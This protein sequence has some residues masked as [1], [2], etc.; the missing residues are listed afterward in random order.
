MLAMT[1]VGSITENEM[2]ATFLQAEAF[3]PRFKQ[4]VLISAERHG[5]TMAQLTNIDISD[6]QINEKRAKVLGELRGFRHNKYLFAGLPQNIMWQKGLIDRTDI[7]RCYYAEHDTWNAISLGTRMVDIG[8][9]NYH[10]R[11]EEQIG[12]NVPEL[13]K[14]INKGMSIPRI[15]LVNDDRKLLVFEGHTR[16][17]AYANT[18]SYNDELEVIIG[19]S[20]NL[21]DWAWY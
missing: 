17:T 3:S 9:K 2:V 20:P 11:S 16:I 13:I 14:D 6:L 7:S 5:L 19:Y 8:A 15:I 1:I 18:L 10:G 12:K 21:S 4:K